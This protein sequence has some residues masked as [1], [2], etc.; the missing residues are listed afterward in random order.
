MSDIQRLRRIRSATRN[1]L[2]VFLSLTLG[3]ILIVL[4]GIKQSIDIKEVHQVSKERELDYCSIINNLTETVYKLKMANERSI[5]SIE[6]AKMLIEDKDEEI[7]ILKVSVAIFEQ[8]K[9]QVSY[10]NTE[11][12]VRMA[13]KNTDR[14]SNGKYNW[15][16]MISIAYI[17]SRFKPKTE[18]LHGEIG[19]WQILDW[20]RSLKRID[21]KDP[22]N[23]Y[24]NFR[25]SC[26]ALNDKFAQFSSFKESII[27]YNGYVKRDG[28]LVETYWNNF[29]RSRNLIK[30]AISEVKANDRK[31]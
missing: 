3:S 20:Q 5:E 19:T 7:Y 26:L 25:M 31:N 18:G 30:K 9:D 2:I 17:E 6:K 11:A 21:E 4:F 22:Y 14:F 15:I 16:D 29:I 27:A 13:Y 23:L 8:M 28:K 10:N 12:V 1:M 24:N